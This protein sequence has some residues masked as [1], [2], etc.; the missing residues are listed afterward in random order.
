MTVAMLLGTAVPLVSAAA[1]QSHTA[2]DGVESGALHYVSLGASNTNGYGLDGYLPPEVYEDPL[3]ASKDNLN[4]YGYLRNPAASYPAQVADALQLA[5]GREV[6]LHQLALSSMRVE[7]VL[8]LL[9][10]TYTPDAYMNWRFTGG[11]KWFEVAES[12]GVPALREA[13]RS[14]IADADVITVDLGWNNFGV[15]AFNNIKTILADGRFWKAP[16]MA[17]ILGTEAEAEYRNVK[18]MIRDA[19]MADASASES[20]LMDQIDMLTDVL[21]YA[22]LGAC[23]NFDRVMEKIYELNPDACVSVINIQNL[24]DDLV[25]DFEGTRL[26]LGSLYGDLIDLVD[27]Y[28]ASRSPYADRYV[29]AMV[30]E[31]GD[32]TTFLDE[33]IAW[34]GDPTTLSGDMKDCFDMYDDSLYVRSIVEYLMVGQALS[35]VFA[36]MQEN[37]KDFGIF[38]DNETYTY[39]FSMPEIDLGSLDL[40]NPSAELQGYVQAAAPHLYNIRNNRLDAYEAEFEGVPEPYRAELKAAFD[41]AIWGVRETYVN[42]VNYAYGVVATIVQSAAEIHT[43]EMGGSSMNGFGTAEDRLLG[44]IALSF[45]GDTSKSPAE[46]G[47]ATQKFYYE[48]QKNGVQAT[49]VTEDP[50]FVMDETILA[51]PAVAAVAVLAA[52]YEL[53]NS[54]FAHPNTEGHD[55]ITEAVMDSL[56]NGSHIKELYWDLLYTEYPLTD[57]SFYVA[58]TDGYAD[59]AEMLAKA[60]H[61]DHTSRFATMTWDA[62]DYEVMAKADLISIGYDGGRLGAFALDQACA[63]LAEYLDTDLRSSIQVYLNRALSIFMEDA[64]VA[65]FTGLVDG[66]LDE[67]LAQE[68]LVGKN[69]Q[70]L[71][72]AALLGEDGAQ[73]V[74]GILAEMRA[75][76]IDSGIP[77]VYA[78]EIDIVPFICDFMSF[79]PSKLYGWLGEDAYFQLEIPAADLLMYTVESYLYS[80]ISF[81]MTYAE[82]VTT[83][84]TINPEAVVILVGQ[85][86]PYVGVEIESSVDLGG[87]Y[88]AVS[89]FMTVAPILYARSNANTI[90]VD[91]TATETIYTAADGAYGWMDIL[92][93]HTLAHPSEA[94]HTY[95]LQQILEAVDVSCEHVYDDCVDVDCNRCGE[96]RNAPGHA[97]GEATCT[98]AYVCDMCG[99]TVAEA[100]GHAEVIDEAIEPTCTTEGKTEGKHCS[101]CGEVLIP[102]EILPATGHAEVIDEA[103]EPT[104]TAE[105]KTEGKHCSV[106]G[107]VLIPQEILS[108]TG[109]DFADATCDTPKTCK[110]CGDAEGEAVGHTYDNDCDADCNVCG[111]ARTPADHAYGAWA[112]TV[113]PTTD[114]EG[115]EERICAVCGHTESRS[116][117]RL[118]PETT[119]AQE[120]EPVT[121]PETEAAT[122]PQTEAEAETETSPGTEAPG[123]SSGCRSAVGVSMA[124]GLALGTAAGV[125]KKKE[126]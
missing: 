121:E 12:G 56:L 21:A 125:L 57:T 48:L 105:G 63:Y 96:E 16:D 109:H 103:I 17:S 65:E 38:T 47:G 98:E 4:V 82:V 81:Q 68:P 61:L 77:E 55:Q 122:L 52:R 70:P 117:A 36:S 71:D 106:C 58:L 49:G 28:R 25:V 111:E 35:G 66:Y 114:A 40:N 15:Y 72:W 110:V 83:L 23:Y 59:Y 123:Q 44:Y 84:Q 51:D 89:S 11:Q 30:G 3:A 14:F 31:D 101:V 78:V 113:E 5:T 88:D 46:A 100:T 118:E 39:S 102:Q 120:T 32:V 41:H 62:L 107:E 108:A 29:F 1:E 64:G 45:L 18:T 37:G 53:G 33:L 20:A 94:G 124:L 97:S 13:Y 69:K 116:L 99:K 42:T 119:P 75:T 74:D 104:C 95:I 60:L 9:D 76:L 8:Y 85:Y 86:N 115:V 93:D 126:D 7:E 54:F 112:V 79:K 43:I 6:E 73:T 22:T 19:L 2:N 67:L 91:I 80:F 87:L 26:D 90:Y 10:E 27:M 50:V 24:A 34:D 92:S